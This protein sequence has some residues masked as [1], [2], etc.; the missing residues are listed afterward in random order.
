M[1]NP[2][3]SAPTSE[4]L[5]LVHRYHVDT[6]QLLESFP[7][8]GFRLS[9]LSYRPQTWFITKSVE[10]YGYSADAF[11]ERKIHWPDIVHPEDRNSIIHTLKNNHAAN[12]DDFTLTYR[13]ITPGGEHVR[14]TEYCH[15]NR[16]QDGRLLCVDSLVIN[17]ADLQP[18]RAVI[19]KQIKQQM[20]LNDILLSLQDADLDQSLRLILD[21]TGAYLDVSR[22]FLLKDSPDHLACTCVH[23][24]L[25]RD[26]PPLSAYEETIVYAKDIPEIGEALEAQGRLI[27]NTGEIP[28]NCREQFAR[29]GISAS[30]VFAVY[31]HGE[32][33]GFLSFDDCIAERVWDPAAITFLTYISH[34]VST[35]VMRLEGEE[36]LKTARRT[37]ETVLDNVDTYIFATAPETDRIIFANRAFRSLF[38]NLPARETEDIA[39]MLAERRRVNRE[40]V[41]DY[42]EV[43]PIKYEYYSE[44]VGK[45]LSVTR[46]MVTWVDGSTANLITSNDVTA[47]KEYEEHIKQLAFVDHLT[48]LP[49]RS[50]HEIDL[51]R[52]LK[53]SLHS[54]RPGHVLF[55]DLDDFKIVN[56]SYG[57]DYGDGVLIAFARFL[58]RLFKAISPGFP[59]GQVFRLGGD[60]F[61]AVIPPEQE[62]NVRKYLNS[63]LRRTKKPWKSLDKEFYCSLSIGVASWKGGSDVPGSILKKADIAMYHAKKS[64]KNQFAYY[65]EGLEDDALNR[66][67]MESL[68][69]NAMLHHFQGFEIYYQP[70]SRTPDRR[71]IGAEAL[72]RL[73]DPEGGLILPG[74]FMALAERLELIYPLGEHILREA[75]I[76]CKKL[77]ESGRPDFS[78]TVNL[79]PK[80][81][82]RHDIISRF[83][84]VLRSIG[85]PLR[86]IVIGVNEGVAVAELERMLHLGRELRECGIQI[87]LDGFG[88]G[89]S[90][91]INMR[92][93]PVDIIKIS[94]KYIDTYEDEFTGCFLKLVAD[95]CRH[96]G[97][98]VCVDGVETEEQYDFCR[99]IG[100]DMIQG[101][102]L[103]R[104]T[105]LAT[106]TALL[107]KER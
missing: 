20:V 85:V 6:G 78:I 19:Q 57:H 64:G 73:K 62:N 98:A 67:Q 32:R 42:S 86:N 26:I 46:E 72:V 52:C 48:G 28:E 54:S 83:L 87:A 61:I 60:E 95:L 69:R 8:V 24:W 51:E 71:I 53:D 25:N 103:H 2:Y 90:S 36:R 34:I 81:F 12:V 44:Q 18:D 43:G 15:I 107:A 82:R 45:W 94:S 70:Y 88:S 10:Q 77:N 59:F 93:L 97:K 66:S 3:R 100:V 99:A 106:L 63:M 35:V 68:L 47:E 40:T 33:F 37:C 74:E 17:A 5:A 29:E 105:P 96:S 102:L 16:D 104:P 55:I 101:F 89:S 4:R 84:S 39:R 41:E 50:R 27:I 31:M 21:R 30:A 22:V 56:D 7:V 79:S 1:S 92:S 80:Q 58:R 49:N 75:A 23:Q 14:V 9:H 11:M 13:I 91:F 76:Q 38:S 65:Q